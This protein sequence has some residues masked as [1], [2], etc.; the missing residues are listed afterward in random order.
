MGGPSSFFNNI[1]SNS[2]SDEEALTA[3]VQSIA[4][5]DSTRRDILSASLDDATRKSLI[6]QI[7]AIGAVG[8]QERLDRLQ[9]II[10]TLNSKKALSDQ[11]A[12]LYQNAVAQASKNQSTVITSGKPAALM[13]SGNSTVITN[14]G[15]T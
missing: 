4:I 7:D 8:K 9:P 1:F 14:G 13:P 12:K 15:P 3:G 11:V 10:D 6:T 2:R 5:Q